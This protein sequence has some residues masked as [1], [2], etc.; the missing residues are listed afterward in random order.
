MSATIPVMVP[1][2]CCGGTN[3][4]LGP[5]SRRSISGRPPLCSNCHSLERHRIVR[6]MFDTFSDEL[7]ADTRILQFSPDPALERRRFGEVVVSVWGGENSLDMQAIALP[8]ASF[9]WIYSTHVMNH[10][11]DPPA[12]LREMLRVVG[13]GIIVLSVGGTVFNYVTADSDKKCGVDRQ[14][15]V[16]GTLYADEI[17]EVLPS[18]AVLELV[19][20]DPC[21]V[22]LDSVYFA[23]LDE[24]KLTEMAKM[25]VARNVHARVFPANRTVSAAWKAPVA[26]KRR[27]P[28]EG[29][30][31]EIEAWKQAGGSGEFWVR[32]DDATNPEGRLIELV[33]LCEREAVPLTLAVIPLP[34][35][36]Q[37]VELI[38]KRKHLTPIQHGFD[39]QNRNSTSDQPKSEFPEE[40]G[41][42]EALRSIQ[43]GWYVLTEAFGDR[44]L[45][46]F[47]P[48]WGTMASKFQDRLGDLGFI[49]YSGSRIAGE[50]HRQGTRPEGLRL[51]S[52]HVAVNRNRAQGGEELPEERILKTL[53]SVVR[54]IRLDGA[55]EPVGVMTHHWGV[56]EGVRH[57][58][59]TLFD[60]TRAAGATWVSARDL[61]TA[62]P[63]A[64]AQASSTGG[65]SAT[66]IAAGAALG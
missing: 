21:S 37:L 34:M 7:L 26:I 46:V 23:S 44:A 16:Y 38:S 50:L 13:D 42:V 36:L 2:N 62:R 51:A 31:H 49:G 43:L 28:W 27:D 15:K 12:A 66:R 55:I 6:V 32:D 25:A 24:G 39:H 54:A 4:E 17:Q 30:Q 56:D 52:A 20:I 14:F 33:D 65:S 1:C 64:S 59:K 8:D 35:T 40:R 57:F 10:L 48:P 61:F 47:C 22:S 11:P 58:L 45:P 9:D 5:S 41:A 63:P 3:F 53:T 60:T 19:A 18:V 29:L